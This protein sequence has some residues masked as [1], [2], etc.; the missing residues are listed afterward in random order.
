MNELKSVWVPVK[1]KRAGVV[2]YMEKFETPNGVAVSL[3]G[4]SRWIE[5]PVFDLSKAEIIE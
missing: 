2:G 1:S 3:P 5:G 4:T